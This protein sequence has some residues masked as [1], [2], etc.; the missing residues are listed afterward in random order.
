MGKATPR[1][2]IVVPAFNEQNRIAQTLKSLRENFLGEDIEIIVVDDGSTDATAEIAAAELQGCSSGR[3]LRAEKNRGKGAAVRLGIKNSTGEFVFITD[4]DEA[5]EFS[6]FGKLFSEIEPN[7]VV[8]GSRAADGSVVISS[9]LHRRLMGRSFNFLVRK[10]TGLDVLDTQCGFKLFNGDDARRILSMCRID[11]FAF[12]V[13]IL[14]IASI[15]GM[16]IKEVPVVW[17]SIGDSKVRPVRDSLRTFLDLFWIRLSVGAKRIRKE[18]KQ[19]E[20]SRVGFLE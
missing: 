10:V 20:R 3:V 17:N 14:R 13:E 2:S 18:D 15:L 12:D 7:T 1:I 5:T 4:A 8:I 9:P 11:R 19:L 6:Y 16:E